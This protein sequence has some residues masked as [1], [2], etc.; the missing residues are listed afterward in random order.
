VH[1]GKVV[2]ESSTP[3]PPARSKPRL[4]LTQRGC[5]ACFPLEKLA[6]KIL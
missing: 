5:I 2:H 6:L 3:Q 1:Q 4:L